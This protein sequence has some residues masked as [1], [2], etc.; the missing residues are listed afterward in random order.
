MCRWFIGPFNQYPQLILDDESELLAANPQVVFLAVAIEDLLEKLPSPWVKATERRAEA[1]RRI[2]DF[3]DLIDKLA[4][5]LPAATIF[6]NDFLPLLPQSN[7]IRAEQSGLS[8]R[9]LTLEADHALEKL[10]IKL[11]NLHIVP[12]NEAFRALPHSSLCDARFLY[13]GKMR[14][15][16]QA[17]EALAEHY[18]RLLQAF[19]GLRKKCIV[20]DLD[21]TLWG[22]I[23]GE[24]GLEDLQLSGDGPGKAFQDMQRVLLDYYETGTVVG[25]LQQ[26]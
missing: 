13:A 21:N 4:H 6:V 8:L 14:L 11:R 26:E 17:M 16:R 23:L 10:A 12:L 7:I 25:H 5:R 1:D 15:G 18:S 3:L 22:G 9:Q 19:V 24:D 20:L 2:A